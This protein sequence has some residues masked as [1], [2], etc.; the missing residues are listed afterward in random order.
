V[1]A[2]EAATSLTVTATS[3]VDN[4]KSGTALVT[5][6]DYVAVNDITGIASNGAVGTDLILAGTVSPVGATYSTIVWTVNDAGTT[7][8]SISGN[9]LTAAAAGTVTVTATIVNGSAAGTPYTK[10]FNISISPPAYVMKPVPAGTVSDT[11]TGTGNTTNWGAGARADNLYAKPYSINAFSIGETE[12]TYELWYAVYTWALNN[13]YTF[14]YAGREGNDGQDGA[15][16]TS[17]KLEPVTAISWRDAVVWCNAYSEALG[18]TPVYTYN[19]EILRESENASTAG[20]DSGK[21]DQAAVDLTANGFRL[22]TEAEW[23]YA[24]RGGEP[25]T[26][27]PWT[28]TYAGN[29]TLSAVAVNNTDKTANVKTKAANS[30]GLY[31]MSGNVSEWCWNYY[32]QLTNRVFR[33][34][35]YDYG[36][37]STYE[38]S[39]RSGYTVP[40]DGGG[41]V[42]FRVVVSAPV[43]AVTGI[44]EVPTSGLAKTDLT[45]YGTVAPWNA[46]NKTI[47]WSVKDKGTTGAAISGNTLSTT[48]VGTVVVTATIENGIALGTDYIADFSIP[49]N[50]IPVTGISN[51]PTSGYGRTNLT[52]TGTVSP[53][54]ATYRT[55]VWSVKNAGT[56]GATITNTNRLVTTQAGTVVVTATIVNGTA[57]GTNYTQDFT[58]AM[59]VK[60][61]TGITLTSTSGREGSPLALTA[62]VAPSNATNQTIVWTV[63]DATMSGV[64]IN[65]GNRLLAPYEGAVQVTATIANGRDIGWNYTQSFTITI[66]PR[67]ASIS[68][69]AQSKT[70]AL[71]WVHEGEVTTT[72]TGSGDTTNWGAGSA[73]SKPYSVGDFYMGETEITYN[74]W[75]AIKTWA[76]SNG[77]TF[78]NAGAEGN[79]GTIGAAPTGAAGNEPVTCISWCDAVV[80]CNAY[81]EAAGKTPAYLYYDGTVLKNSTWG[82]TSPV[83]DTTADGFRLPT[84]AQWEYAARGG[85]PSTGTPWT[86]TYAGSNTASNVA[87]YSGNSG[88]KTAAVKSKSGNALGLYDMSGNVAEWCQNDYS[89]KALRGGSWDDAD[90]Y[91]AV[92]RR[93]GSNF[94]YD[95]ISYNYGE[96]DIGFRVMCP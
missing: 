19:N 37:A 53:T 22:P 30:L 51:V 34:G 64:T 90:L 61:V 65:N 31:D 12:I 84:E 35:N 77:Y 38:V 10:D 2:D 82:V 57:I 55:I 45:L 54:N 95:N 33:G 8:A 59:N 68:V 78:Q 17:A 27:T 52:L 3:A 87:V 80:W 74:L 81:S 23:E 28:Y 63:T 83:I 56:T 39:D 46:T 89:G 48:G 16:P 86:Y 6:A 14:N 71:K 32:Y 5:V 75:Y 26:G 50:I 15:A 43:T 47:V 93:D 25:S 44:S 72:N 60:E 13:G 41:T 96:A 9:T 1:A 58:I 62:T 94:L 66:S 92:N 70:Y 36:S 76:T 40:T 18:K 21:A 79:D 4:T 7:V 69:T 20:L 73:Y 24:A 49:I 29:D 85:V 11:N 88:N 91:C 67:T 42:G